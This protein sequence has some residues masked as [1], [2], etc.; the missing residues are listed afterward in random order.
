MISLLHTI[1]LSQPCFLDPVARFTVVIVGHSECGGAAACLG[2]VQNPKFTE[3][4]PIKTLGS[5]PSDAPLNSW[6]APLTKLAASL[7]LSTTPKT[8]ALPIV[9]EENV[10]LQV[11]NLCKAPTLTNA[12]ASDNPEKRNVWVHGWV[13]DLATGKLKDLEVTR[14]PIG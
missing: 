3:D 2:A 14:G 7:Q 12:W 8:E 11:E 13:Y 6:L 1:I 9:V 10:K 5:L 4:E